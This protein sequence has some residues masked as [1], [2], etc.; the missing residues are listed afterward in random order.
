MKVYKLIKFDTETNQVEMVFSDESELT[1]NVI[2]IFAPMID[3]GVPHQ[4][5]SDFLHPVKESKTITIVSL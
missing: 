2:A 4:A 1:P 5:I 3:G